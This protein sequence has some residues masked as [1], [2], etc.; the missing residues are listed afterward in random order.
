MKTGRI[1][2]LAVIA[3][4][5]IGAAT[6]IAATTKSSDKAGGES[7]AARGGTYRV[8]WESSFDFT[9]RLRSDRRVLGAGVRHLLQPARAHA[10]RLQPRRRRARQR[11]RARS[12][13]EPR[14]DLERRPHVHVPRSS[15][16]SASARRSTARSRRRTSPT[17]SSASA[18]RRSVAQYGFYYDVI[19]G[20]TAFTVR[21]GQDDLGHHDAERH[22][23][24]SSTSRRRRAT[25]ATGSR[26]RP[27]GRCRARSPA[28]SRSRPPTA[29]TWS[30]R[31]RT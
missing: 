30:P 10:R 22:A 2:R 20:M 29:A 17:R 8:E 25:S 4:C 19:R 16:A 27:P 28:A 7:Q 12:R 21:Q 9:V 26:C 6:A 3:V 11:A 14:D 5:V 18:R 23:R 31:A 1:A 24:S 13:D 15:A